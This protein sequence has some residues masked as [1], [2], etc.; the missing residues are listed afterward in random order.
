MFQL[1]D[2]QKAHSGVKTGADFP[3]YFQELKNLGV[4]KYDTFVGDGREIF[5][6]DGNYQIQS[7]PKYAALSV[8]DKSDPEKFKNYLGIHQKGQTD[9]PTFCRHAAETGVEKW[10]VDMKNMTCTYYDK[11]NCRMLEE[12][13]PAL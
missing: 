9:Y 8:N 2:I 5:S 12:N 1:M 7:A 10:T 4:T 13:I 6:G 11:A 3:A